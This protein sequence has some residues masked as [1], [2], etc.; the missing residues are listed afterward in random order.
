MAANWIG[1]NKISIALCTLV[2]NQGAYVLCT[3]KYAER[4]EG[5]LEL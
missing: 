3:C 2:V 5:T 4:K 1:G